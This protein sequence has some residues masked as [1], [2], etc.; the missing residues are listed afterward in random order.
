MRVLRRRLCIRKAW[1]LRRRIVL[2]RPPIK[3][4]VYGTDDGVDPTLSM[5]EI[6]EFI[7]PGVPWGYAAERIDE[8]SAEAGM[9]TKELPVPLA[10]VL[11]IY[12]YYLLI[13]MLAPDFML[14]FTC[15]DFRF[16]PDFRPAPF[17][18]LAT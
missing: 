8:L 7:P 16:G 1:D 15:P 9:P 14:P 6:C 13:R 17:I 12:I 11:E 5:D 18:G 2:L 4:N 10:I 3:G